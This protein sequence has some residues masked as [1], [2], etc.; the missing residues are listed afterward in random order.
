MLYGFKRATLLDKPVC[1]QRV[2]PKNTYTI[3]FKIVATH[4]MYSI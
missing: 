4:T 3:F 2:C 1:I